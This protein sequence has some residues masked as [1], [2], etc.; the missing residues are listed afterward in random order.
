M[1]WGIWFATDLPNGCDIWIAYYK[2]YE[3]LII[4]INANS[5]TN[6]EPVDNLKHKHNQA[7]EAFDILFV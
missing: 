7:K 5:I 4:H 6:L 3:L 2:D 1:M